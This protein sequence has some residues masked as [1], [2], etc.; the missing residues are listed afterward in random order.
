M[1]LFSKHLE[2]WRKCVGTLPPIWIAV[3]SIWMPF[4]P[5]GKY[6]IWSDPVVLFLASGRNIVGIFQHFC[7]MVIHLYVYFMLFYIY[8]FLLTRLSHTKQNRVYI[9]E[10]PFPHA[11]LIKNGRLKYF[12]SLHAEGFLNEYRQV[13]KNLSFKIL[14][15]FIWLVIACLAVRRLLWSS[16]AP[17]RKCSSLYG[18][19]GQ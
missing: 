6:W 19:V 17:F 16:V 2:I 7:R 9:P 13:R 3:W 15:L 10:E 11:H 4:W 5:F 1:Q 8:S 12:P 14:L 18:T